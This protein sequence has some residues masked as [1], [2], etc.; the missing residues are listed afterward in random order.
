MA[1]PVGAA[2]AAGGSLVY[3]KLYG[4]SPQGDA[5]RSVETTSQTD[6]VEN[7]AKDG[8]ETS[9]GTELKE[10]EGFCSSNGEHAPAALTQDSPAALTQDTPAA[11]TQDTPATFAQDTPAALT[12]EAAPTSESASWKKTAGRDYGR[13]G[14]VFG[15]M[16][17]GMYS[18]VFGSSSSAE[19]RKAEAD[20]DERFGQVQ[21]L[22]RHAISLYRSRGYSGTITIGHTVAYFHES[23]SVRVDGGTILAT[24][25]AEEDP[26]KDDAKAGRVFATL[27]ARLERRAANWDDTMGCLEDIDPVLGASAQ[28]GF[29]VPV[30]QVGWGVSVSLSITK[31]S[32]LRWKAYVADPK[33]VMAA[34]AAA[35]SGSQSGGK[36]LGMDAEAMY[37][38]SC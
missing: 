7:V 18:K 19:E 36:F 30:I 20:G 26:Q 34:E 21:R 33:A 15:D 8:E 23:T 37:D 24:T 38:E 9:S 2:V 5:D 11:L 1:L 31:S 28:I 4:D 14:Y 12:Q 25:E 35:A 10:E 27:L 22:V 32:L 13:D 29:K 6:P 3:K 16:T 17:R